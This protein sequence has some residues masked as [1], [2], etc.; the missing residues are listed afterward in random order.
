MQVDHEKH[1]GTLMG[2][3]KDLDKIIINNAR[4]EM[5][6]KFNLL[7]RQFR[8]CSPP[9]IYKLFN[10]FCMSLYGCQLWDYSKPSIEEICISWRKGVR[11]IYN[12][13]YNTHRRFLHLICND[14]SI[15]VKLHRC[16]L[17]FFIG[18]SNHTNPNIRFLSRLASHGSLS[19]TS[20]N[21][22]IVCSL[23]KID[24]TNVNMS[25]LC[26]IQ[27]IDNEDDVIISNMIACFMENKDTYG[28]AH[29]LCTS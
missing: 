14:T 2:A 15:K 18:V 20:S 27:D 4:N 11:K 23:Y 19:K 7:L 10:T 17:K 24:K 13:P 9:I 5:Y 1:V 25:T 16:F 28:I 21:L 26:K 6:S 8:T 22:N 12:I 29:E 3:R